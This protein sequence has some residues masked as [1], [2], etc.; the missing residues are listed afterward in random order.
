MTE[1]GVRSPM[2]QDVEQARHEV[3]SQWREKNDAMIMEIAIEA[4]KLLAMPMDPRILEAMRRVPRHNHVFTQS[5]DAY[6]WKKIYDARTVMPLED[7]GHFKME[8]ASTSTQPLLTAMEL[9]FLT[10]SLPPFLKNPEDKRRFL[11]IGSGLGYVLGIVAETDLYDEVVGV[12]IK[13]KLVE[14]ASVK[15][16]KYDHVRVLAGDG[17][18]WATRLG[19]FDS[20]MVSATVTDQNKVEILKE[21]L[22]HKGELVVPEKKGEIT[23]LALY[24]RRSRGNAWVRSTIGDRVE[25]VGL[26]GE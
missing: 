7:Y 9:L 10:H 6:G 15:L 17:M 20:I 21:L 12:E 25:F 11:E 13:P 4:G 8:T 18:K 14:E 16:G 5:L 26:Q 22:N 3:L 19:T 1:L 2:H 23:E 24:R